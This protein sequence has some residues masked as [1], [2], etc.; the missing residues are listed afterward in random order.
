MKQLF[1][2]LCFGI[3]VSSCSKNSDD[4]C[5]YDAC[6]I[7]APAAEITTLETYLSSNSITATKHCSGLYYKIDAPG[8]GTTPTICSTVGVKYQGKLTNGTTFDESATQVN[9]ALGRLIE[10]W[11]KGIMLIKP[12]GKIKLWVPPS[13]AYG[14]QAVGTIPA[15]SILYFEVE[16]VAVY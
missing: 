3:L 10:G 2:F 15:N 11:K 5:K 14:N 6:S 16:L 12:G 1:A 9:F 7:V 4:P 13:L 8:S